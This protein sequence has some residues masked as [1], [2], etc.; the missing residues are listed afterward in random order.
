MRI[1]RMGKEYDYDYTTIHIKKEHHQTLKQISVR[2]RI[3]MGKLILK[4]IDIYENS[5]R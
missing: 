1:V 5:N 3:P 4:M 2:E